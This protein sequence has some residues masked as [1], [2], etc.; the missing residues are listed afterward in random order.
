LRKYKL[1][2]TTN[3]RGIPKRATLGIDRF[4]RPIRAPRPA[5]DRF[6]R[7]ISTTIG[8]DRFGRPINRFGGPFPIRGFP[9]N[10]F[11]RRFPGRFSRGIPGRVYPYTYGYRGVPGTGGPFGFGTRRPFGSTPRRRTPFGRYGPNV[12]LLHTYSKYA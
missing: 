3:T 6:G 7:P 5:F 9:I 12:A 10:R 2:S 4:G 1:Y 11:G 8:I